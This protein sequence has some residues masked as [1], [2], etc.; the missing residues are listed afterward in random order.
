M[1]GATPIRVLI[2]ALLAAV[3]V[4]AFV[5]DRAAYA[6]H[7]QVFFSKSPTEPTYSG[8]VMPFQN[9]P[10]VDLHVWAHN[11]DAP[12]GAGAFEVDIAYNGAL[13]AATALD[14]NFAWLASTG[15]FVTC[16]TATLEPSHASVGCDTL[17]EGQAQGPTGSGRLATLTLRPG[18]ELGASVLQLTAATVL[19]DTNEPP[20][21]IPA[22]NLNTTV[23]VVKCLDL[24][25]H[26]FV[27]IRDIALLILRFGR[28]VP[29]DDPGDLNGD[30]TITVA[31]IVIAVMQFGM[32]CPS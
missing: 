22:Q 17:I 15:L 31:D 16:E 27:S 5:D 7:T 26:P 8:A 12:S 29:Y 19:L 11:V 10:P 18:A 13:L 1:L 23:A 30:G 3:A 14:P 21:T 2:G 20:G 9:G 25:G 28:P 24:D 4:L 32:T 6:D